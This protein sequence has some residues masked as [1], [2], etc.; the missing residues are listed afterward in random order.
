M[1]GYEV[2]DEDETA[3]GPA[4]KF[5]MA[6]AT[7][8]RAQRTSFTTAGEGWIALVRSRLRGPV[9]CLSGFDFRVRSV[10]RLD[11]SIEIRFSTSFPSSPTPHSWPSIA[12]DAFDLSGN[13]I[14]RARRA[15]KVSHAPL[16][17][18]MSRTTPLFVCRE[19]CDVYAYRCFRGRSKSSIVC[20]SLHILFVCPLWLTLFSCR[21]DLWNV[22][23]RHIHR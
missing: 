11:R 19:D 22:F 13:N 9:A 16:C 4:K 1:R 12:L 17:V 18:T 10:F 5:F 7:V 6:S 23:G 14:D 21:V 15:W 8:H 2:I 20:S 3:I